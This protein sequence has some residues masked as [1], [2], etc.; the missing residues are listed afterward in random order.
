MPLARFF[1]EELGRQY[2]HGN[3]S[4]GH[5][6]IVSYKIATEFLFLVKLAVV[7]V[8]PGTEAVR[9][10]SECY[11]QGFEKAV[12]ASKEA[13]RLVGLSIYRWLSAK[14]LAPGFSR[15]TIRTQT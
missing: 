7:F 10:P 1:E 9:I 13:F 2:Q 15:N 3:I 14:L 12:A 4:T 6:E 5:E 8:D 11:V